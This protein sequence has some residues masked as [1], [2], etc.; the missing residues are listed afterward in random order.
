MY[1]V[2]QFGLDLSA[3]LRGT[4]NQVVSPLSV[5]I[6]LSSLMLAT[7]S[8]YDYQLQE[9]LY[10]PVSLNDEIYHSHFHQLL[11]TV[12]RDTPDLTV[13][14][15]NGLFVKQGVRVYPDFVKKTRQ[16]YDTH[17]QDLDF[18]QS[19]L[20]Q[21]EVNTWVSRKTQGM[22]PRLVTEPFSPLSTFFIV[23][24]VFFNGTWETPFDSR[25]TSSASFNT[26]TGTIEVP[27]MSR[28]IMPVNYTIVPDFDAHMIAL[29]YKGR[30]FAMFI[31]MRRNHVSDVQ[32][33]DNLELSLTTEYLNGVINNM[34]EVFMSVKLPRMRMT[35]KNSLKDALKEMQ[36]TS[37]FDPSSGV[38]NRM[39]NV[40]LW[41]DD[42]IHEAVVEV[43]ETGTT[44][45]AAT[46]AGLN[47]VGT[48]MKFHVDRPALY[49][50]R[51]YGSDIPLFWGR[52][53]RPE[54]LP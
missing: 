5:S 16:Y 13:N 14:V 47:R 36:V 24:T 29:P 17:I 1:C 4:G 44:A 37:I 54:P 30:D 22:I 49:F 21:K 15:A 42:V 48:S 31:L 40:P 26:T 27:M 43:T 53:L 18:S 39:T 45:S 3:E 2:L 20:A 25:Q 6:L 11:L 28:S 46:G 19:A 50:I 9:A 23:N 33:L 34:T 8:T 52:L 7:N 35:Y 41:V 32:D 38:F 12:I 51:S 10:L